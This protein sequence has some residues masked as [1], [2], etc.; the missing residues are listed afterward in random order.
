MFHSFSR[1]L[2]IGLIIGLAPFNGMAAEKSAVNGLNEILDVIGQLE[3]E[4]DPKCLATASRLENFMYGTPLT[5][6]ARQKKI[7]LQ[8]NLIIDLWER[9]TTAAKQAGKS[10]LTGTEIKSEIDRLFNIKRQLSGDLSLTTVD[11]KQITLNVDDIRQYSSIAYALRAILG[12]QQD[13]GE[14]VRD[15]YLPLEKSAVDELKRL[16]DVLTLGALQLADNAARLQDKYSVEGELIETAWG[17]LMPPSLAQSGNYAEKIGDSGEVNLDT[18]KKIIGQKLK[19]YEA[20]N[21]IAMPVFMRN[22][23]VYFARHRW[24]TDPQQGRDL[25]VLFNEA[26]ISFTKT[27][28]LGSQQVAQIEKHRRLRYSD[29]NA[30][31]HLL[32]PHRIN[33]YEDAIFFPTLSSDKQ[34]VIEAYDMDAFRDSGLHWQYFGSALDEM[35][36]KIILEPDPFALEVIVEN[37]AQFGVLILRKAG[38]IAQKEQAERLSKAHVQ[39]ALEEIQTLINESHANVASEEESAAIVSADNSREIEQSGYYFEDVT[40]RSGIQFRHASADW[41]SRMIRS[42]TVK[43]REVAVLAVPPAFGGSGVA[44]E[45]INNDDLPDV[46][47]L[48]GRGNKLY[49]NQGNGR[50]KDV[51]QASGV[52]WNRPEDELPGEP[53]QPIIADF[54]N[55]GHADIFISYVNDDHRLYRNLG[56]GTFQD[57]TA[58]AGFGGKGLVAGPAVVA[59]FDND[60]LLDLYVGY[61]GQYIEGI[62]P[63]LARRNFNGLP[64]QLFKNLGDFKFKN[65]TAE[66]GVDNRGWTQALSHTDLNRDGLQ[67]IIVG[68]DFGINAY[69]LNQGQGK[70]KN[71]AA[72]LGVDKP[73]YTMNIGISDINNDLL[74]DIYI[75]NIVTMDK[76]Q[77]YV[78]PGDDTP[79]KFD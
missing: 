26:L 65:V 63:T 2:S 4:R 38:E 69:Y 57:V 61:F 11:Q 54:D 40:Q 32:L 13:L 70:F 24:P 66:S 3:S 53:R 46:L 64:N 14:R 5:E 7:D 52:A 45:D 77:K 21:N 34:E 78:M 51:T 62:K 33:E 67:D 18:I 12:V 17:R 42:Y 23:Q 75:S 41:L 72:S 8:K 6:A 43:N 68:N 1:V 15:R 27:L 16:L 76:D 56:N 49:L 71:V 31:V 47:L 35:T 59:D 79:M 19:S 60:G 48:G 55:D 74:P 39:A 36:D 25:K 10:S 28:Y 29:V 58:Q 44:A 9:A 30:Y 73:S 37:I 20:Y 50:F 22:I